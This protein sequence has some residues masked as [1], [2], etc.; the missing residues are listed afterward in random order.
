M[1]NDLALDSL[2]VVGLNHKTAPLHIRERLSLDS[3][4][5]RSITQGLKTQLDRGTVV[6]STCNRVE[7]YGVEAQQDPPQFGIDASILNSITHVCDLPASELSEHL[8]VH[9]GEAALHHLFRVASSLDSLVVGEPQ[10]LGQL[11]EA[12]EESKALQAEG[13]LGALMERAF[14]VA[15]RVR[16]QT[17]IARHVVSVSSVAVRLARHIFED[18]SERTALLIGAGEMGE[19]AARHLCQGGV[20]RLLVANR[21]LDRAVKLAEA[22]EGSPR[23]L[24]ALPELLV[25]ADIV[26][27]STGAREPIITKSMIQTALKARKYRP[28]FIID[29]AVPRDVHPSVNHLENVYVYDV[30]D[31]SQIADENKAQRAEEANAAEELIKEEIAKFKLE[32]AKRKLGPLLAEIRSS[33]HEIKGQELER[34]LTKAGGVSSDEEK[35]L[36]LLGDR[37]TNKILHNVLVGAKSFADDSRRDLALEVI[38]V[39]FNLNTDDRS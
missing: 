29:I 25:S 6:V 8:Y 30:D 9:R 1:S 20:G 32:Q 3:D 14:Q 4:H 39:L 16:S 31:L 5:K 22:L 19:L 37:L 10:I 18:L 26:I 34:I 17:G 15:R 38:S 11:K 24:T 2:I 12:L 7:F 28:L 33:V 35:R 21:N 23:P 13:E 27:S 36:R